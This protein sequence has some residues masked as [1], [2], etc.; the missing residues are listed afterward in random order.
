M[1]A[2]D[3]A[4]RGDVRRLTRMVSYVATLLIGMGVKRSSVTDEATREMLKLMEEMKAEERSE[5]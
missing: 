5:R 1:A 4:T 2:S 3:P